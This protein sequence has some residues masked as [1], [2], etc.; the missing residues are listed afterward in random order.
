MQFFADVVDLLEREISN[1]EEQH[2][3]ANVAAKHEQVLAAIKE[4]FD[5]H[6]PA[7][8]RV[9]VQNAYNTLIC[10]AVAALTDAHR[11]PAHTPPK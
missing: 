2:G 5:A 10:A 7:A 8:L 11:L 9:E 1:A 6:V 3:P 4:D